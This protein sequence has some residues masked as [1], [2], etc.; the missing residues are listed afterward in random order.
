MMQQ[1]PMGRPEAGPLKLPLDH[2]CYGC[3]SYGKICF[4]ICHRKLKRWRKE[5][6]G[7]CE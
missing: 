7:E 2:F 6:K 3:S 4:G 1:K 5:K